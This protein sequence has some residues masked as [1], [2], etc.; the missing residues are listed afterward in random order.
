MHSLKNEPLLNKGY[1]SHYLLDSPLFYNRSLRFFPNKG[2]YLMLQNGKLIQKKQPYY[3]DTSNRTTSVIKESIGGDFYSPP[4]NTERRYIRKFN[5]KVKGVVSR[6]VKRDPGA[7]DIR[8]EQIKP[9]I[10][11]ISVWDKMTSKKFSESCNKVSLSQVEI[12]EDFSI[13]NYLHM[14]ELSSFASRVPRFSKNQGLKQV[15]REE[16]IMKESLE[17]TTTKVLI[18]RKTEVRLESVI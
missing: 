13:H 11:G 1:F 17:E 14:K 7:Y 4:Q 2:Y 6:E 3:A 9:R 5:D 16:I 15:K 12:K 8:V 18:E 10:K